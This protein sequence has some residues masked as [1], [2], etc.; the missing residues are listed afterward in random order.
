MHFFSQPL[1]NAVDYVTQF[2]ETTV[3]TIAARNRERDAS[4]NSN[5]KPISSVSDLAKLM[6][7]KGKNNNNNNTSVVVSHQVLATFLKNKVENGNKELANSRKRKGDAAAAAAATAATAGVV[8]IVPDVPTKKVKY[9]KPPC[10][11]FPTPEGCKYGS[12]CKFSH[13]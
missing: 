6:S 13:A 3:L 11:K 7:V 1:Q 4:N 12:K 10:F 5:N 8:P 9:E 2:H